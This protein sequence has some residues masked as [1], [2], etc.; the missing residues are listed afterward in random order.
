MQFGMIYLYI[1]ELHETKVR[2][3]A[4]SLLFT[5][6]R[7]MCGLA[8]YVIYVMNQLELHP[9]SCLWVLGGIALFCSYLLP[10]TKGQGM[11]N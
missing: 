1:S 3:F 4:T 7:S 9:M 5:S 10:E 8:T 6:G 2:S 11:L